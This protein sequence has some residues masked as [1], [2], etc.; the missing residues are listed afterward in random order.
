ML[1]ERKRPGMLKAAAH[2]IL[3][4]KQFA[5]QKRFKRMAMNDYLK[6]DVEVIGRPDL[7][8]AA[9]DEALHIDLLSLAV[10]AQQDATY[11]KAAQYKK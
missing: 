2:I 3:Y 1:F 8:A 6:K 7:Q 4:V 9:D 5:P 11:Q 10:F